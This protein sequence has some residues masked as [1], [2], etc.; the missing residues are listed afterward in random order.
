MPPLLEGSS[1][2]R[3]ALRTALIYAAIAATWILVS[4]WLLSIPDAGA[5]TILQW[6]GAK[7]LGFVGLTSILLFFLLRAHLRQQREVE[8]RFS[9]LGDNLPGMAYRCDID[10]RWTMRHVSGATQSV[11][12]YAPE[13]LLD[14]ARVAYGDLIHPEDRDR[15]WEQ[16]REALHAERPFRIEYRLRRRDGKTC[17]IWEQ[18]RGVC[19]ADLDQAIALEGLMLDITEL[20]R[21]DAVARETAKRL[22]TLGDNLPG[23]AIYR[24]RRDRSGAYR[25]TYASR[26]VERLLGISRAMM[27]ADARAVFQLTEPPYDEEI[28][29][30]NERSARDLSIVDM[31]LPQRLP[32]GTRKW[33]AVRSMPY[34]TEDGAVIWDGFVLDIT[35]RKEAAEQLREAAAVFACTA[36]G[37]AITALDGRIRHVNEAFCRITRYRRQDL[38]GIQPELLKSDRHDAAFYRSIFRTLKRTGQWHGEIWNRRSDGSVYPALLTISVVPDGLGGAAGYVGAFS[39]ITTI[40]QSEERLEHLAHHDPV[41]D[42]PN[43]LLFDLHLRKGI[44][45]ALQTNSR[46][47]V[48]F[49]DL[50][51][52]KHINDSLGHPAGDALLRQ[53][54]RR[55]TATLGS[56]RPVGRLSGDEFVILLEDIDAA[57]D[58]IPVVSDLLATL[59]QPFVIDGNEVRISASIGISLCPDDGD[60]VAVLLR[61]ADAAMYRAKEDG[62]NA[63]HFYAAEMTAAAFEH[64]FLENGLRSALDNDEFRLVYQPQIDVSTGRLRGVEALLRWHHPKEGQISPGRFIPTAEQSGLIRDIGLWV[65]RTA[66]VQARRWLDQ[67]L[68]F[69]L[70]AVNIAGRQIHDPD[71]VAHVENALADTG[72]PPHYLDLEITEGFV[73]R[74]VDPSAAE[75]QKLRIRGV[76]IAIDD[77]GTGYSSLNHLKRLPIT[78]LKIDQSFVR[79]IPDDPDN[80]ALCDA[81][82][83]IGRSLGMSVV[84][85]GV[86]TQ[87]QAAFLREKGCGIL[88]GYLFGRPMPPDVLERLFS[89]TSADGATPAGCAGEGERDAV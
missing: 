11:T 62:G 47:A 5:H 70:V 34:P 4:D 58:A 87:A 65:L 50:D 29:Q 1:P 79:D 9:T 48:L 43:R 72:L 27:L 82:I 61:N 23:G 46:L 22:E 10:R 77:F 81:V 39:D 54:A 28:R 8:R 83:A 42:L 38:I 3:S 44:R 71:F 37:V 49:I 7:G 45:A 41:T 52:F 14:N 17:W 31:E 88:Q 84:A 66:C 24:L 19:G 86:E 60:T 73:M 40:K 18:G 30:T 12:G 36:E 68:D 85:E 25:F 32:D 6:Q 51:R 76:G 20:K 13:D 35:Q 56:K 64:V 21:V 26:G 67:G 57:A 80:M 75:L 63:Y 33:I 78:K 89:D 2:S 16:V 53:F 59:K 55:L 69:G 15:V 74:A